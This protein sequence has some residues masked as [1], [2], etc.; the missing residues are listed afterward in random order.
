MRNV[1]AA[2]ERIERLAGRD[3]MRRAAR[4]RRLRRLRARRNDD[5]R[6][7]TN[8]VRV[9][10]IVLPQDRGG[11]DAIALRERM[12]GLAVLQRDGGL[13]SDRA[14]GFARGRVGRRGRGR[15]RAR[16][17]ALLL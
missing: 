4:G 17:I 7:W 14:R 6:T 9:G 8:A 1:I 11:R 10:E 3:D 2:R 12:D 13:L 15:D 5:A 16:R